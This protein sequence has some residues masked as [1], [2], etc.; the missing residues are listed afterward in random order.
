[1]TAVAI[2]NPVRIC[3]TEC[4]RDMRVEYQTYEAYGDAVIVAAECDCG[5]VFAEIDAISLRRLVQQGH[6]VIA[7]ALKHSPELGQHARERMRAI[8]ER[9][10]EYER[11][12][13]AATWAQ[14][15]PRP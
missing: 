7:Q 6:P 10:A 14:E 2:P 12:I 15:R 1:M 5:R 4:H 3:C 11:W 13:A 8:R 9:M